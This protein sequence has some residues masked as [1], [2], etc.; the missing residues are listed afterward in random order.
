LFVSRE[1]PPA[2]EKGTRP[3]TNVSKDVEQSN[4]VREYPVVLTKTILLLETWK[5]GAK[6]PKLRHGDSSS[7]RHLNMKR[8]S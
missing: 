4:G 6:T 8:S 2:I 5:F 7:N 1:L 3:G